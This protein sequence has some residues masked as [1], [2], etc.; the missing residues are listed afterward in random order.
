MEINYANVDLAQ[1]V[2]VT[3]ANFDGLAQERQISF[4]LE[5]PKTLPAQLDS[6][7]LQRVL[8]NLLS[9][10]F[11]FTLEGGTIRCQVSTRPATEDSSTHPTATS[12]TT[13]PERA[14]ITVELRTPLNAILGWSKNLRSKKFDEV[15]TGRAME[16]IERNARLQARPIEELL[17][18]SRLLRGELLLDKRAVALQPIIQTAIQELQHDAQMQKRFKS[19]PIWMR[20]IALFLE[21]L[22]GCNKLFKMCF[23]MQ[24]SSLHQRDE[25]RSGFS[26][27]GVR[28]LLK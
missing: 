14:V 21:I 12:E 26:T 8:L 27:R 17:D 5:T 28:P 4:T 15:T 24:L 13:L 23:Q 2:S 7:K 10:A 9:N 22:S 16:T 18:I 3:A 20:Q 25:L 19:E 6:S 1:L 11:K